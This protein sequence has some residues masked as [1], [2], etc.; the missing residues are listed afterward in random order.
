MDQQRWQSPVSDSNGLGATPFQRSH[1]VL[2]RLAAAVVIVVALIASAVAAPAALAQTASD[3]AS[4]SDTPTAADPAPSTTTTMAAPEPADDPTTTTAP[5]PTTTTTVAA[6]SEPT[7]PAAPAE[8]PPSEPADSTTLIV[9]T[10]SVL[11]ARDEQAL[12]ERA[13][14]AKQRSV[15]ALRLLM[16][17]VP[18]ADLAASRQKYADDAA[19]ERVE[20]EAER[21]TAGVPNDEAYG[22]QWALPKIGWDS[23]FGSVAPTG[24]AQIAVLDTGVA[25]IDDLSVRVGAG[26]SAFSGSDPASDP[27][28]HGTWLA[29]IAAAATDNGAG[30]AGVG[31]AGVSVLP[32]QVLGADGTGDDG[33]IIAGLI[34]AADNGADVILMG[35]SN[36]GFSQSLQDAVDYAWSKGAVLVAATGNEGSSNPTYPA[37]DAKVVGVSATDQNDALWSGSNHGTDTF[38]AAPGVGIL[39]DTRDGGTATVTGTSASSAV[40][41]GA[42]ALLRANDPGASNGTIVGRLGRTAD[43]AGTADETGN[44]RV[45]LGRAIADTSSE[46]VVPAGAPG[47]GPFVGPYVAAAGASTTEL[48]ANVSGQWRSSN[49][50]GSNSAY[51]EGDTI[52]VRA[53]ARLAA[54]VT[55]QSIVLSWDFFNSPGHFID[56]ITT[57]NKTV[58]TV[59]PCQGLNCSA[60]TTVAVPTDSNLTFQIPGSVSGYNATITGITANYGS[61]NVA[62]KSV[63]VTFSVPPGS[64][65]TKDVVIAFGAHLARQNEFGAGGGAS[66]LSGASS[67]VSSNLNNSGDSTVSVNPSNFVSAGGTISGT[68]YNDANGNGALDA[69]ES[70]IGGV[71]LALSGTA[72]TS[73]ISQ[74]D[75]TYIFSGLSTGTYAVDYTPPSGFLNTGT[76]PLTGIT[77]ATN[78][79]S[80]TGKN[81]FAQQRNATISG[82][83]FNDVNNDGIRQAGETSTV[84]GGSVSISGGTPAVSVGPA[85]VSANGTYSFTGLQAGS[86]TLTYSPPSGFASTGTN[87]QSA[88]LTAGGSATNDFLAHANQA[89]VCPSPTV[90]TNEDTAVGIT[91][92]CTDLES[93]SLT[94]AVLTQP[95]NGTLG[96][97]APNLTYT[98]APNFNGTDSFTYRANDGSSNSNTGTVT[99]NVTSVNDAP[100][101]ADKTVTIAEDG[102]YTFVAGDFG[103]SDPADTPPNALA[104]VKIATLPGA[105]SL[106]NNGVAVTAG[107]FVSVADITG[108]KLVVTPAANANG[109]PYATFTFQVQ[110]NGGTGGGGVDLDQ[111]ANTITVNVTGINDAP[112]GTDK[113]VTVAEE[114]PYAFAT[115]DFGFSDPN[116]SPA[117]AL[118]AVRIATL[119]GAG[120]LT[121]NGVAVSVGQFVSAADIN[122]GKL[123]FTPAA[124]A[125]GSPYA[126]FTFQVQ[127]N[128]GTAGGGVDLDQ[129]ANTITINVDNVNDN[130]NAVDDVAV[131]A[132]DS[133]DNP[134]D[135]LGNDSF[136]PDAGETLT[137]TAVGPAANG[138]TSLVGGAVTYTPNANYFGADSFT[139]TI[140]D[141]NGGSDTATVTITVDAVN[142]AP[143]ANDDSAATDEDTPLAAPSVLG[144]DTDTE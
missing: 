79:S 104:A 60:T 88:T 94:Y 90:S 103:F 75:G 81:F 97:T 14:G 46:V 140:S 64:P 78:T 133:A 24:A 83:V 72:T 116:D 28:G 8:T 59:N 101:G 144:N 108:G 135:V 73:A 18:S 17:D 13:G 65:A 128:G 52:P 62:A 82:T 22:Q 63:T 33:D 5:A 86:Y 53:T 121:N 56:F 129:S 124:N 1:G 31:Y 117:N 15:P 107:Q 61:G 9:K 3:V 130:P 32:V 66:V 25:A 42:A 30:I 29:S 45:N 36:P 16:V 131:V 4:D 119:P 114:S 112:A 99:I 141:G 93:N 80:V 38:I 91:L 51:K 77:L 125:N 113:T 87:P 11:A 85:T 120:S 84:G 6:P 132:E 123:V 109:S 118:A 96:G 43:P 115:A 69:G 48:W 2:A 23:V 44:G 50:N 34:W 20:V 7:A 126:S 98:P 136:A 102:S 21:D 49:L 134:V 138:T 37:G 54:G 40:V 27:N 71:T 70:G 111:S 19:V 67:K 139:Y 68:V 35:F 100:S 95:T 142:D 137:V 74:A 58:T 127:D 10:T 105:G 110:D 92:S 89:P 122:A 76:R 26:W 39:A 12:I 47:G 55:N 106:T 41:A 57:F 143:V